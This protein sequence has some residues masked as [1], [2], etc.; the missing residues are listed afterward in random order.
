MRIPLPADF[1]NDST[2]VRPFYLDLTAGEADELANMRIPL[3]AE[4]STHSTS[5]RPVYIDFTAEEEDESNE[6]DEEGEGE[7]EDGY[8]EGRELAILAEMDK[9]WQRGH[10]VAWFAAM[11]AYIRSPI[12]PDR[13]HKRMPF[14]Q[15]LDTDDYRLGYTGSYDVGLRAAAS[16]AFFRTF[17]EGYEEAWAEI[18]AGL[19]D[20]ER[21]T[22]G[23]QG[24]GPS[25]TRNYE[26]GFHV[27]NA[28]WNRGEMSRPFQQGE[29]MG[30]LAGAAAGMRDR[31]TRPLEDHD[32]RLSSYIDEVTIRNPDRSEGFVGGF[33]AGLFSHLDERF[34]VGYREAQDMARRRGG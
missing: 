27:G 14:R 34:G 29:T 3:P 16:P 13:R 11:R 2:S 24:G 7:G 20:S 21:L 26:A 23:L 18:I 12:N 17:H 28:F 31:H 25:M 5:A 33:N 8:R 32:E 1:S 6:E 4:V 9:D 15:L 19:G 10:D 30:F 22:V